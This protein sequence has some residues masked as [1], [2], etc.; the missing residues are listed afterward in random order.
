MAM[1]KLQEWLQNKRSSFLKYRLPAH[2]R[3]VFRRHIAFQAR[4]PCP[5]MAAPA[6][7]AHIRVA[8]RA[9][10]PSALR[11][12]ARPASLRAAAQRRP[13]PTSPDARCDS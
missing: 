10:R 12:R 3:T 1:S 5:A 4:A 8:L 6:L 7:R 11:A 13:G 2:L 9:P